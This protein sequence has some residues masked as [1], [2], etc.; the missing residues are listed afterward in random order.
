[1]FRV[2]PSGSVISEDVFCTVDFGISFV[3]QRVIQ[4]LTFPQRVPKIPINGTKYG[5]LSGESVRY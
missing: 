1:M 2:D 3:V 4:L 5:T